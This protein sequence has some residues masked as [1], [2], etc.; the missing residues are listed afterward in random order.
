M[1]DD[2][3]RILKP[4][5]S[6]RLTVGLLFISM[7]LVLAGTTA[8]RDMGIQDVLHNFFRTWWAKIYFHYFQPTPASGHS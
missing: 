3:K 8:Q 5:A 6:L 7:L 1:T 4:V 2:I